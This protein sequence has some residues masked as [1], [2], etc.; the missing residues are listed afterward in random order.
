MFTLLPLR[1]EIENVAAGWS[2]FS[3]HKQV[4]NYVLRYLKDNPKYLY[5]FKYTACC[6]EVIFHTLLND[7]DGKLNI[8]KYNCLRFIEWHPHRPFKTLP[9]V[10][11]ESEYTEIINSG[12]FFCRKIH[13][14]ESKQLKLMLRER[15]AKMGMRQK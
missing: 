10:L 6:D 1:S 13:P 11:K 7:L 9:L 4:V 8:D 3:W 15:I 14:V 12:S 5:R 2:W